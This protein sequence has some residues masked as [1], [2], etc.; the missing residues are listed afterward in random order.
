[1]VTPRFSPSSQT[2]IYSAYVPDA[3]NP[4]MKPVY[5]LI[6]YG[7]VLAFGDRSEG[8]TPRTAR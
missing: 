6:F 5:N 4:Q 8:A 2:I 7:S 1:M 3:K